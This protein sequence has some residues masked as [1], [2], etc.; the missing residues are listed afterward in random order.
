MGTVFKIK[1]ISF[2]DY[3]QD[4]ES[5]GLYTE[6]HGAQITVSP[7]QGLAHICQHLCVIFSTKA[8][9][10]YGTL[11]PHDHPPTFQMRRLRHRGGEQG[12]QSDQLSRRESGLE[13][14]PGGRGV[15]APLFPSSFQAS[16]WSAA[17]T[18]AV[19]PVLHIRT[20][21]HWPAPLGCPHCPA[22]CCGLGTRLP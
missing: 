5:W 21:H 16:P 2:A 17:G 19:S 9:G 3:C 20:R 10:A 18:S 14:K 15:R 8:L 13:P 22:P 6:K 1:I 4:P 12:A 11:S 7:S